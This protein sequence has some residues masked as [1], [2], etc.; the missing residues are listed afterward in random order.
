MSKSFE[1]IFGLY[2]V[3]GIPMPV[4]LHPP[5]HLE[6]LKSWLFNPQDVIVAGYPK[7]GRPAIILVFNV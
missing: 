6:M 2:Q 3:D 5:E 7:S 4:N 1:D